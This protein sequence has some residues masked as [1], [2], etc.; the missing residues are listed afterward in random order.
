MEQQFSFEKLKAWQYSRR[1]VKL[2][3]ELVKKLPKEET[4]AL[5]D[6]IRRAIVSVPSN[7]AEGSGRMSKA[8]QRHFYEISYGSLMEV[9]NQLLLALDL[10][11]INQDDINR[12]REPIWMTA[13]VI[14]ALR[15]SIKS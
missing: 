14:S 12:I 6:Q 4:Y 9:Y 10:E 1:L 15:N 7:I 8:E 2:V 5:S 3:Y 11:Y 13:K